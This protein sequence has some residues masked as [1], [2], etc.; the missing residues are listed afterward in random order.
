LRGGCW[1]LLEHGFD[2]GGAV[3]DLFARHGYAEVFTEGDLG[4]HERVTGG[5]RP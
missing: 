4:G 2:Q 3:R 1:L 5:R